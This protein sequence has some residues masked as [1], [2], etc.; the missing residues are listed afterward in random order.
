MTPPRTTPRASARTPDRGS[1]PHKRHPNFIDTSDALQRFCEKAGKH[2]AIAVDTEFIMERRYWADLCLVQVGYD[3]DAAVIDTHSR[4]LD[5]VPLW[6]LMGDRNIVKVFHAAFEDMITIK[7]HS[8]VLPLPIFDTQV[9]AMFCMGEDNPGYGTLV[10][11]L[12]GIKLDKSQQRSDWGARPLQYKQIEYAMHDVT[13]LIKAYRELLKRI[14]GANREDWFREDHD[15][16]N[17]PE[18]YAGSAYASWER[19]RLRH[20]QKRTLGILRE[21]AAWRDESARRNDKP[22]R[23]IMQDKIL[24]DIADAYPKSERDL[25]LVRSLPPSLRENERRRQSLWKAVERALNLPESELPVPETEQKFPADPRLVEL[26]RLLLSMT[27]KEY[28]I[29]PGIIANANDL[30]QLA[31]SGARASQ[32]MLLKGWRNEIFGQNAL[33]LKRGDLSFGYNKGRLV[34]ATAATSTV[35]GGRGGGS[36]ADRKAAAGDGAGGAGLVS[37]LKGAFG[38]S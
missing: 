15:R 32:S 5:L 2:D 38:R 27:A 37:R 25:L 11:E 14:K 9:A 28:R 6:N 29:A 4:D 36:E 31:S 34:T 20:P 13:H 1:E 30:R 35:G 22:P 21:L 7:H 24:E 10:K 19:L 33:A 17:D 8:G 18:R 16:I 26:L 12:Y 23:W 3:G